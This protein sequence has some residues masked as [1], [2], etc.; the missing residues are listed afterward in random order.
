VQCLTSVKHWIIDVGQN[1]FVK[2]KEEWREREECL[3]ARLEEERQRRG[4]ARNRKEKDWK[5]E[6]QNSGR[7][8]RRHG[9]VERQKRELNP[10]GVRGRIRQTGADQDGEE[11]NAISPICQG[12]DGDESGGT[13]EA[14][15]TNEESTSQQ[16]KE[17]SSIGDVKSP[18]AV[19]KRDKPQ[20]G[21]FAEAVSSRE[22]APSKVSVATEVSLGNPGKPLQSSTPRLKLSLPGHSL[23]NAKAAEVP[24]RTKDSGAS[25]AMECCIVGDSNQ[26]ACQ[27][28]S[29]SIFFR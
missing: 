21:S 2:A 11:T 18:R 12:R 10:V 19:E 15:A 8:W 4:W 6:S 16:E 3:K 7:H 14:N 9:N 5:G 22:P 29:R 25:E 23:S 20:R 1:A 27:E 26:V 28:W 13:R 24:S 17:N